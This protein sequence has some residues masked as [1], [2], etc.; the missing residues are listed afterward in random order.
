[1]AW[2]LIIILFF[3]G[4]LLAFFASIPIA[5]AFFLMDIIAMYFVMGAS[6]TGT[7]V[8]SIL[9]SLAKFTLVPVPLFVLMGEFLFQSGL[10]LKAIDVIEKWLGKLPGRL[11]VLSIV[12]GALFASLSGSTL[13]NTAMLGSLL[14]P[15]MRRRNYHKSMIIGPITASGSLAMMIP[16]SSLTVVFGSL[17]GISVGDLLIAGI[18]PGLLTAFLYITYTVGRCWLNKDLAPVYDVEKSNFKEII[19]D[20]IKDVLPLVIIIFLTVG[21]IFFGLA[22]P[23]EAAALGALGSII[24]SWLLGKFNMDVVKKSL[25]GSVKVTSMILIIVAASSAFS[26]VLAFTGATRGLTHFAINLPFSPFWI[27][28][29]MLGVVF[30]LGMFI[31]QVSIMMITLPIFMPIVKTLHFTPVWFGIL[32]LLTLEISLLT[33][34]V[35]LLLYTIKGVTPDDITMK[36]IWIAAIPYVICGLVSVFIIL[37]F[38]Q[39]TTALIN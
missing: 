5:F 27:L 39:I 32:M 29:G 30:F 23:T 1:M 20:T 37:N 14:T 15:E 16:P 2:W 31:E 3:G 4:L 18:L 8:G 36:D 17:A 28:V 7:F 35:G 24:L 10:A 25:S 34:P 33:P 21:V 22:T 13:A 19:V 6:F 11:S 26:Q 9:D 38:P 12:S